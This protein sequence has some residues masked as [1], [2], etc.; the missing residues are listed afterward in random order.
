[1]IGRPPSPA[2][3]AAAVAVV[4]VVGVAALAAGCGDD[5]ESSGSSGT[6]TALAGEPAP[7]TAASTLPEPVPEAPPPDAGEATS[8]PGSEAPPA[9]EP[10][11]AVAAPDL[12]GV[13]GEF[14]VAYP[15]GTTCAPVEALLGSP[16]LTDAARAAVVG[17]DGVWLAVDQ[18]S[19]SADVLFGPPTSES[20]LVTIRSGVVASS[21]P[22][23]PAQS[24]AL[25]PE[26]S[27]AVTDVAPGGTITSCIE[28]PVVV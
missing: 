23:S 25:T 16:A 11:D 17:D 7:T 19:T 12:L 9:T 20:R 2:R 5:D 18:G 13:P 8:P 27:Y 4:A 10:P 24:P 28:G 1:V 21:G 22:P 15:S 3:L 14:G 26:E 6:T